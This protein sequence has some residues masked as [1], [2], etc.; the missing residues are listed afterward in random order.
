VKSRLDDGVAAG[1][2][3]P[4]A[5]EA[6]LGAAR[7]GEAGDGV[8]LD[9]EVAR[10]EPLAARRSPPA[11]SADETCVTCGKS[12]SQRARSTRWTPR[13]TTQPPPERARS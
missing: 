5:G 3:V 4:G 1:V 11:K 12:R 7:E 10:R 13:S 8:V 6:D 9:A 2:K